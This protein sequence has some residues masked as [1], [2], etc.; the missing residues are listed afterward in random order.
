MYSLKRRLLV[1]L[2]FVLTLT[3]FCTGL[4]MYFTIQT[5]VDRLLDNSLKQVALSYQNL[6]PA[7]LLSLRSGALAKD[8][9]LVVQVYDPISGFKFISR[10]MDFL[11]IADRVG[12]SNL[13]IEGKSW[14]I[15]TAQ[16]PLGQIIEVAQPNI[17]R[18]DTAVQA[19]KNVL[20][21]LLIMMLLVGLVIWLIVGKGFSALSATAKAIEHRSPASLAPLPMKGLPIEISPLVKAL[22]LLLSQLDD[23]LK[24]QKRFASDAAHELK[25]PLT[26][27]AMQV[28]LVQRAKTEEARN[29]ALSMLK[30]GIKR[31]DRLIN[32]LLTM[33]RLDPENRSKS[34]LPLDLHALAQSVVE[35]LSPIAAKKNIE[36]KA[37][38]NSPVIV[39]GNEDALRLLINNL[40]DNAIRYT[41]DSGH[42][43]INTS[44]EH[45]KAEIEV[46][47]DG[48]GI[49]E[50]E[51]ERIFERFYRAEGTRT[52][53]G[54]GIGLAIVRRVAEIHGGHPYVSTGINGK[55]ASFR[56]EFPARPSAEIEDNL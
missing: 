51:R 28:Q 1:G 23:S 6:H 41:Q 7:D 24:A 46:S 33:T 18:S 5:E 26:A 34:L 29:K 14:R 20:L 3:S 21:P 49:P 8:Q 15:Y 12:F 54:T 11:P 32:Q 2:I 43:Q 39:V 44:V 55:G 50:T 9:N 31:A 48:P 27:L 37:N 13:S 22:N 19:A 52:I 10:K 56:I 17:V 47:D 25:T 53:P 36:I 35:E 40:C 30:E 38:G 4:A 42:I 16:N 45:D